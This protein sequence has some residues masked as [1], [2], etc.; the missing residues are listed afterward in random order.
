M[1]SIAQRR[2]DRAVDVLKIAM[3]SQVDATVIKGFPPSAVEWYSRS[4]VIS[5]TPRRMKGNAASQRPPWYQRMGGQGVM[6]KSGW[7]QY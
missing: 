6:Q 1:E 5:K 4:K 2:I 3:M 7:P